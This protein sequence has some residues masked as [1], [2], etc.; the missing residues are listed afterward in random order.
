MTT[1]LPFLR[2]PQL[3]PLYSVERSA[4]TRSL[5]I[6]NVAS[7]QLFESP[8]TTPLMRTSI[9]AG[10]GV[11]EGGGGVGVGG[12]AFCVTVYVCPA[13]F[14][15]PTRRAPPFAAID[16]PTVPLPFPLCPDA[17]PIQLCVDVAPQP[18]PLTVDTLTESEP[19]VGPIVS[20]VRLSENRHGAA[21]CVTATRA[22]ATEIDPLRAAGT[23]FAATAYAT[24]PL[25]CPPLA[26]LI[27]S[28]LALDAA[29]H[30][31]SRAVVTVTAALP[32]LA[33]NVDAELVTLT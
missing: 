10:G 13:T 22:D 7:G 11:G 33:V 9:G 23:R 24:D 28:Q 19:P 17:T 27:D 29:L 30:V 16:S 8:D 21:S 14:T 26:P 4:T 32:P 3:P 2:S 6:E 20:P 5:P 18:Q 12:A 1:R 15:T 31:Q 25:P